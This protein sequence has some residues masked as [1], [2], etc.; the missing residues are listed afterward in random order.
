MSQ[1][2][3]LTLYSSM[4]QFLRQHLP[5]EHM[6]RLNTLAWMVTCVLLSGTVNLDPWLP[7]VVP[8]DPRPRQPASSRRRCQRFLMNVSHVDPQRLYAPFIQ[9]AL[10][11][12]AGRTLYLAIDTTTLA[13]RLVMVRVSLIY[14]GRAVPI[15]WTV[16]DQHSTMVGLD[17]YEERLG[18]VATLLPPDA[19]PILLSD[20][21][22]RD[23]DLMALAQARH[24]W[25]LFIRTS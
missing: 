3:S 25:P 6:A 23:V 11:A 8:P 16:L 15:A 18:Y 9:A 21:G 7:F 13:G 17:K 19:H 10:S 2:D 5:Q 12:W 20:Q 14:R 4:I 24:R 1:S 22:F